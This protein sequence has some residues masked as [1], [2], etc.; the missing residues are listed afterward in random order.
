MTENVSVGKMCIEDY[1]QQ[2]VEVI[3]VNGNQAYVRDS[4]GVPRWSP[5][6]RFE[7]CMSKEKYSKIMKR[8]AA[9]DKID[10]NE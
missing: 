1:R 6:R 5:T 9:P 7:G 2:I 4:S 8:H 3:G 10:K